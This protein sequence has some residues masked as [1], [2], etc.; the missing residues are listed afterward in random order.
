MRNDKLDAANFFDNFANE[1]KP[2]YRQNQY[3]V[4]IGGPADPSRLRWEKEAYL[5]LRLL[6]GISVARK[7]FTE[8]ANVPTAAELGGDFSDILTNIPT[9]TDPLGRP[10]YQGQIFNPY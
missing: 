4:T 7:G 9:G 8:F 3:G 2:P 1:P 10:I 6:G 5:F